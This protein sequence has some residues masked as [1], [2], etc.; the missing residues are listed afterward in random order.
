MIARLFLIY[1]VIILF[2]GRLSPYDPRTTQPD[3]ALQPPTWSH[4]AGTDSL[5]RD[6]LSRALHGGAITLTN[7]VLAVSIAVGVGIALGLRTQA[8]W[9][10]TLLDALIAALISLPSIIV[11]LMTITLFG[12]GDLALSIAVGIAQIAPFAQLTRMLTCHTAHMDYVDAAAALGARPFWLLTHHIAPNI[13][14]TLAGY[15]C[16]T[17]GMCIMNGAALTFLGFGGAIGRAEWGAMLY[18]GRQA[19]RSAPW[20]AFLPGLGIASAVGLL[21][22]LADR[23]TR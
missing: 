14:P 5:G 3:I 10:D 23:L 17:F 20:I 2:G 6:V 11:A 22:A 1:L 8:G 9:G 16:V 12:G 19:F 18:E 15:A 4:P 21:N 13:A 7:A